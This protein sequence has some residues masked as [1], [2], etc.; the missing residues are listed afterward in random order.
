MD[1]DESLKCLSLIVHFDNL[2]D[3]IYEEGFLWPKTTSTHHT[4]QIHI[5]F[6]VASKTL[7]ARLPESRGPLTERYKMELSGLNEQ[8]A[9]SKWRRWQN[10][11]YHRH[12]VKFD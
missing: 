8:F 10:G 6:Q 7:V 2:F 4:F 1:L 11:N 3:P 12:C 9:K 5:L